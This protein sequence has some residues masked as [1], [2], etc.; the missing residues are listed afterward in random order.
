[1]SN[2]ALWATSTVPR[3]NSRNPGSTSSTPGAVE[4]IA[5]VIPVSRATKAGTGRPGFTNDWNSPSTSPPRTLTAP[6]SVI[7]ASSARLPVVSRSTT[8]KVTSRKGVPMSA[9]EG[10][11]AVGGGGGGAI[12]MAGTLA[13]ATDSRSGGG[14]APV[15]HVEG[16]DVG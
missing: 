3:A 6:I 9:N 16:V 11:T 4:T 5:V 15:V 14:L 13:L 1:M 10:W 2:G 7:P 12:D 8:T